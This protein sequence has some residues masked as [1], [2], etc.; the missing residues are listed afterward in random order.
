MLK[1]R[2][3]VQ[4][5]VDR[6]VSQAVEHFVRSDNWSIIPFSGFIQRSF[7]Y[8]STQVLFLFEE[9]HWSSIERPVEP[10]FTFDEQVPGGDEFRGRMLKEFS[11]RRLA[12][13]NSLIPWCTS[14]AGRSK[15]GRLSQNTDELFW[16]F[17]SLVDMYFAGIWNK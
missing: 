10:Y 1:S 17:L 8:N 3:D 16:L 6:G 5:R 4:F 11:V 9:E 7:T 14:R 13:I 15:A 12:L 2:V